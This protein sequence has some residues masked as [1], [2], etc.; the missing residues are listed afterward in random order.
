MMPWIARL[1]FC[2]A[3]RNHFSN[4]GRW[5]PEEHFCEIMLKSSH[6]PSRRYRL[7]VF[8]IFSF[9]GLFCSTERIHFGN[10]GRAAPK[11]H[12]CEIILKSGHWPKRRYRFKL[13]FFFFSIFSFGGY[14]VQWRGNI[15]TV[16]E[17]G[18]C[19][20]ENVSQILLVFNVLVSSTKV[21]KIIS[22]NFLKHFFFP[23][24]MSRSTGT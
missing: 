22:A 18:I 16:L 1:I 2:S 11:E 14:F 12:F 23:W 19:L 4:F 13:F 3:E 17:V 24:S 21:L 7:N 20:V 10:F 5:S 6:R 15:L 8:S 9:G